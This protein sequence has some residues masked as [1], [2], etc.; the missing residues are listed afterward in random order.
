MKRTAPKK[1]RQK[2]SI[3]KKPAFLKAF[4]KCAS[5]TEAAAAIKVDRSIHYDWL[6]KDPAYFA[7]FERAKIEAAQTLI[8]SAVESALRGVYEPLTYQG[9]FTYPMEEYEVEP[10]K[11]AGDWKDEG[12]AARETPAKMAWRRIP[13]APPLGIWRRSQML[14]LALLRAWV[15]AFRTNAVEVSGAGGGAIASTLTI[16]FVQPKATE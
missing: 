4:R 10:A 11:P 5:L 8:D 1:R 16:E 3:N 6:D 12:G 7:A 2:R 13:G 9:Q 14:H 15:P